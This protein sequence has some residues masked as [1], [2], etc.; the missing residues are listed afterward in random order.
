MKIA[1]TRIGGDVINIENL[2]VAERQA[3]L[4]HRPLFVGLVSAVVGALLAWL[5]AC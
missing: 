1:P 4:Y 2:I 5:L 3:P